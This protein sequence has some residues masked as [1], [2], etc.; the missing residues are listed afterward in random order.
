MWV[1]IPLMRAALPRINGGYAM[2]SEP[3]DAMMHNLRG[4]SFPSLLMLSPFGEL[5]S[6]PQ[7]HD[8][9]S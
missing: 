6:P 1:S 9:V 3:L 5:C 8:I 4:V 7:L 2:S